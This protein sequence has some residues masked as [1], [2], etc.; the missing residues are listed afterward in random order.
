LVYGS[1]GLCWAKVQSAWL[2]VHCVVSVGQEP[3]AKGQLH[4]PDVWHLGHLWLLGTKY[5]LKYRTLDDGN[6]FLKRGWLFVP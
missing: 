4:S 5:T 2:Y 3:C 6:A 1:S